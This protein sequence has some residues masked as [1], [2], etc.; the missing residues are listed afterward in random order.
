MSC[1]I[2][3]I[4]FRIFRIGI[5]I[6]SRLFGCSLH[7]FQ[8]MMPYYRSN[9][10]ALPEPGAGLVCNFGSLCIFSDRL[11]C[12]GCWADF[13]GSPPQAGEMQVGTSIC[14]AACT[15]SASW[16]AEFNFPYPFASKYIKYEDWFSNKPTKYHLDFLGSAL[17]CSSTH[18]SSTKSRRPCNN[19]FTTWPILSHFNISFFLTTIKAAQIST[20]IP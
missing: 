11:R 7:I 12:C 17:R 13:E 16:K 5:Y 6:L 3:I 15:D 10:A 8:M 1:S 19:I 14:C 2:G 20:R 4:F 9:K 18:S